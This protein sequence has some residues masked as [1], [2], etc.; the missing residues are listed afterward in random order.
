MSSELP[1]IT[2]VTPSF[3]QAAYLDD[4]IRSILDQGY[5]NLEHMILDGGSTDGSVEIIRRHEGRLAFWTSEKDGG[6]AQAINRGFAR[7]TGSLLGWIN[8]D[9]QLQPG[10]LEALAAA[11]MASPGAI[12][13]GDGTNFDDA[14]HTKRVPAF[15]LSAPNLI[16]RWSRRTLFHQQSVFFPRSVFE[17]VGPLDE[18]LRY[19][20]DLDWFC[21]ALRD[22]PVV[23]LPRPIGRYRIHGLQK[24]AEGR[25]FWEEDRAVALRHLDVFGPEDRRRV[26]AEY[27]LD[28]ASARLC[29]R[30]SDVRG[31]LRALREAIGEYP[32]IVFRKRFPRVLGYVVAPRFLVERV[33]RYRQRRHLLGG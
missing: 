32:A 22:T 18:T 23:H 31:G 28:L 26:R 13:F 21:R 24:T 12:L 27:D 19:S 3:N 2:V 25:A 30:P 4:T 10:S 16:D 1:R 15:G 8:S 11:H 20:F 29:G 33:E 14:G 9:D 5:P 17:R 7:A 6:Q